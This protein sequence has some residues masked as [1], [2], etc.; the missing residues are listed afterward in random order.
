MYFA[1]Y[2][3]ML[4]SNLL[5][6]LSGNTRKDEGSKFHQNFDIVVPKHKTSHL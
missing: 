6:L 4:Q 3:P 1:K 5:P 2:V